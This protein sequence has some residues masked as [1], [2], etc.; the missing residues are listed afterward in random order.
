MPT[1]ITTG[2]ASAQGFGALNGNGAAP[3]PPGTWRFDSSKVGPDISLSNGNLTATMTAT[4]VDS[5][6]LGTY[7][8]GA[9]EKLM[10]S[11]TLTTYAPRGGFNG[12]GFAGDGAPLNGWLGYTNIGVGIYDD[13]YVYRNSILSSVGSKFQSSGSVIDVCIDAANNRF[14][15]RVNGGNWNNNAAYNPATNTGGI[16]VS[17]VLTFPGVRP[18]VTPYSYSGTNGV[19]TINT[20]AAYASPSGF[21]FIAGA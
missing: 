17:S 8:I 6:V 19:W 7:S 4:P 21:T 14:W 18:G 12:V 15:Y 10:F 11:F 20:N 13:G 16:D 1:I 3:P 2:A 5:S 9:T